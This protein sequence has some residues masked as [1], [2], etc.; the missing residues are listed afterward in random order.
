MISAEQTAAAEYDQLSKENSISKAM[1]DQDEKYKTKGYK[2]LDKSIAE[3]GG[4]KSTTQTELDAIL[5]YYK[6]IQ[7]R[8]IIMDA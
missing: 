3:T 8:W 1:K 7:V 2:G 4:D 5:D 6:G